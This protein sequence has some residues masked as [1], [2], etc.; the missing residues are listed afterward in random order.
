M[1][2]AQQA[3]MLCADPKFQRYLLERH[4]C[5]TDAADYVRAFCGVES[6]AELTTDKEANH[7]WCLMRQEYRAWALEPS[8]GIEFDLCGNE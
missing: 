3:G 2:A 8:V 6:R 4:Q 1:S 7:R 5:R